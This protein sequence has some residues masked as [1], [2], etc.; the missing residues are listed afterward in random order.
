MAEPG[1]QK[2]G[3]CAALLQDKTPCASWTDL[4]NDFC[5][6][7]KEERWRLVRAYKD[8]SDL[9]DTLKPR[10]VT[11]ND[12]LYAL[13]SADAQKTAEALATTTEYLEA[14]RTELNG[15]IK[16]SERFYANGVRDGH[17]VRIKNL[18]DEEAVVAALLIS[19]R[20]HTR[21]RATVPRKPLQ[22]VVVNRAAPAQRDRK[23]AV[24]YGRP[25]Y[26]QTG[27]N[28]GP[29]SPLGDWL[30]RI[31]VFATMAYGAYKVS[32]HM[33]AA[34]HGLCRD[35]QVFLAPVTGL[36]RLVTSGQASFGVLEWVQIVGTNISEKVGAFARSMLSFPMELSG[37][38]K[39]NEDTLENARKEIMQGSASAWTSLSQLAEKGVEAASDTVASPVNDPGQAAKDVAEGISEARQWVVERSGPLW[40]SFSKFVEGGTKAASEAVASAVNEVKTRK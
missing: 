32:K 7:H 20:A 25:V 33:L 13:Y 6:S 8:A 38:M 21:P 4:S 31:L 16:V 24:D 27:G 35:I 37:V 29:E 22:P 28:G 5:R 17:H 11:S 12:Q 23:Y 9:A 18:R 30:V 19:L 15:R 3:H 14:L 40:T 34:V 39:I 10:A 36:V 1:Q 2:L 26:G